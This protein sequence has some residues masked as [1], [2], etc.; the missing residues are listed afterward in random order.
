VTFSPDAA[1]TVTFAYNPNRIKSPRARRSVD[2]GQQY[3]PR[4]L[5]GAT[6]PAKACGGFGRSVRCCII[7]TLVRLNAEA[8]V[9]A[10]LGPEHREAHSGC[11][12]N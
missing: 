8:G 6:A 3:F 9:G 11:L 7:A 1:V 5:V 12:L 4:T 10:A 2:F